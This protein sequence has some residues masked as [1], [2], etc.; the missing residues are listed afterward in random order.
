MICFY[1]QKT[2]FA[3]PTGYVHVAVD[4]AGDD[5]S[6]LQVERIAQP[7]G[8]NAGKFLTRVEHF[9]ASEQQISHTD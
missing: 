9:S 6:A 2:I 5:R 7:C 1:T 4:Q 3:A 8:I